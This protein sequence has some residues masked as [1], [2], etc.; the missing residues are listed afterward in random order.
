MKKEG[1]IIGSHTNSHPVMSRL[2]REEQHRELEISFSILEKFVESKNKT[3]CHPYGGFHS[4]NEDTIS[5][6]N[7]MDVK[8]S[9]NVEPREINAEDW[10]K[11]KH[12]LPRFNCNLFEYGKA[13]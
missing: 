2:T 8:Y 4:F 7:D 12:H 3:Y 6:L 9:F 5:L 11:S 13:S 10:L 1:M